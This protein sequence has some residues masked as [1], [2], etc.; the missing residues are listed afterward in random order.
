[1][2]PLVYLLSIPY[3][4]FLNTEEQHFDSL[5]L[6]STGN[7]EK[8]IAQSNLRKSLI[9]PHHPITFLPCLMRTDETRKHSSRMRTTRFSDSRSLPTETPPRQRLPCTEIP[10]DRDPQTGI[11]WTET[12][13]TETPEG[14]WDQGERPPEGT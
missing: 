13:L 7:Q 6:P 2:H 11:P 5:K 10:P 14:T 4:W 3:N 8:C 1:M 9:F 12:P